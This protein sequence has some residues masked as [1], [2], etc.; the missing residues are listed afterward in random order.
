MAK[1]RKER[2]E[3]T[4]KVVA[5]PDDFAADLIKAIN[6]ERGEVVAFNLA[7]DE[8]P[9]TVKRWIPSGSR[10]LNYI[11]RNAPQGG[12]PEGRIIEIFGPPSIGK[13]HIA[14]QICASAQR[15]GGLAVYIDTES[16]TTVENLRNLGVNVAKGFVFVQEG[17]VES[18][19]DI[20]EK[21]ILKAKA[22]NKDVPVVVIWDSVAGSSPKAE[23][24]GEYD[25]DTIGLKARS[26]SKGMRKITNIVGANNVLLVCLNQVRTKIGC[27]GPETLLTVR[28]MA[29]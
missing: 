13:S 24:E 14:T 3:A 15:M 7:I 23:L 26:L 2:P 27:V 25:K 18:I 8:A 12:Y 17:C 10:L 5:A 9:T 28:K 22:M 1:Q 29:D 19:F 11:I 20:I 6:K 21:A 16:A 4:A